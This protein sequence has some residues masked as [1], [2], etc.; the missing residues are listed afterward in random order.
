MGGENM[1]EETIVQPR[2]LPALLS[3]AKFGQA[4]VPHLPAEP[5]LYD[6]QQ[7]IVRRSAQESLPVHYLG[8]MPIFTGYR[9]YPGR[10]YDWVL[11]NLGE[12][13]LFQDRDGFP[14]PERVLDELRRVRR[15]GVD[16]DAL[17]VAHEVHLGTIREGARLTAEMLMPPPPRTVQQLS[18]RLGAAGRI[19][20]AIATL[21]IVATGVVGG[22]IAAGTAATVSIVGL[23]PILLGVVVGL[24]RP[25][26]PGEPAAWFYLDHWAFNEE[27]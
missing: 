26:V 25:V 10:H 27:V 22:L 20:W 13:P 8:T 7:A 2:L 19:A 3:Q 9:V 5:A 15:S 16:F 11:M 4:L 14:V 12:D 1:W 17:Y 24:N 18:D 23:D 6:R 21:P